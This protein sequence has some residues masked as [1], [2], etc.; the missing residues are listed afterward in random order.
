MSVPPFHHSPTPATTSAKSRSR[1]RS[2]LPNFEG[3]SEKW[4][5]RH[6]PP[7]SSGSSSHPCRDP[8]PS[9]VSATGHPLPTPEGGDQNRAPPPPS[10]LAAWF[11]TA[12]GWG[13]G[14]RG[15]RHYGVG[16]PRVAWCGDDAPCILVERAFDSISCECLLKRA[17]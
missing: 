1:E 6:T 11:P 5:L 17:P 13:M 3:A 15:S 14:G 4:V 12:A 2:P 7:P 9:M 10:W 16:R 8:G